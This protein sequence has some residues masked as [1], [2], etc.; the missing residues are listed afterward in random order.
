MTKKKIDLASLD[1]NEACNKSVEIE[2]K[3]PST[4]KPIGV[5]ISILGAESTIIRAHEK[6]VTDFDLKNISEDIIDVDTGIVEKRLVNLAKSATVSW[7]NMVFEGEELE[8]SSENLD[9][10][11]NH[12]GLTWIVTQVYKAMK[13]LKLFM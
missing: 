9:K 12:P 8:F 7:I 4:N 5:F 11:Y 2:L 6:K 10:I 13:N 1:V 3:H